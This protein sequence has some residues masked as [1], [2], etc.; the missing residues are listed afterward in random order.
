MYNEKINFQFNEQ[1]TFLFYYIIVDST[2]III[3]K[4]LII[5]LDFMINI[6]I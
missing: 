6:I 3:F 2:I 4:I 1:L 5:T